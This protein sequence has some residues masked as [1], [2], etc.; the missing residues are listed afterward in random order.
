MPSETEREVRRVAALRYWRSAE[1][2]V[3]VDAWRDS[4]EKLPEFADRYG[5]QPGRLKRWAGRFEEEAG[6]EFY[7]LRIV[8]Q[9]DDEVRS[10]EPIEIVLPEKCT[11]RVPAGFAVDD[12]QRVLAVLAMEA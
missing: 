1:A 7:P 2:R 9:R 8:Q 6:V 4:G 12:L 10:N 5:I 3:A 11:V